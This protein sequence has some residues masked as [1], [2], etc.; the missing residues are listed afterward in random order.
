MPEQGPNRTT[1]G[2][3][4]PNVG[5][6][7]HERWHKGSPHIT[8][9]DTFCGPS[10]RTPLA[11]APE[12]SSTVSGEFSPFLA[13]LGPGPVRAE[14]DQPGP[15]EARCRQKL[16]VSEQRS[17]PDAILRGPRTPLWGGD[18]SQTGSFFFFSEFLVLLLARCGDSGLDQKF[19]PKPTSF[20]PGMK[21]VALTT[22]AFHPFYGGRT[23]A[24][25]PLCALPMKFMITCHIRITIF[26]LSL[27]V[28]L[29]C[30]AP[31]FMYIAQDGRPSMLLS[32]F[33]TH[34]LS[35]HQGNAKIH[36]IGHANLFTG[37][38]DIAHSMLSFPCASNTLP[39]QGIRV[40]SRGQLPGALGRVYPMSGPP[41]NQS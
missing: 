35:L 23:P 36:T 15:T 39:C 17:I 7:T 29:S 26:R 8:Q 18:R 25:I 38:V 4:T 31:K 28:S 30:P 13:H 9:V 21:T 33:Y 41:D 1:L 10:H 12:R 2:Q 20:P 5:E 16:R 34:P 27:R 14:A 40:R 6:K 22:L 3:Q 37:L 24:T 32:P 11:Q 19:Q